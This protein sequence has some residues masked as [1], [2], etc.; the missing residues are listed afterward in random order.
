[1]IGRSE[2]VAAMV[3]KDPRLFSELMAGLW[4]PIR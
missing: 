3:C 2:E 4:S 1:M